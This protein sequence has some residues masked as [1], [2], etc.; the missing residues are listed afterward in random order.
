MIDFNYTT[1]ESEEI[2]NATKDSE[3][4]DARTKDQM[5]KGG[6]TPSDSPKP[7]GNMRG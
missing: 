2:D 7:L 4:L 3:L 1:D 5:R 6:F